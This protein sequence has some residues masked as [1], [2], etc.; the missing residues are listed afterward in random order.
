MH[1]AAKPQIQPEQVR[2]EG[3]LSQGQFGC[4]QVRT[5]E[6]QRYN[7]TRDLEGSKPGQRVWVEGYVVKTKG[8]MPGPSLMP[9]HAG[10]VGASLAETTVP[11]GNGRR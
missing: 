3:E 1:G 4:L 2:V 11:A 10:L 8:C 5:A 7:L 6:G 9:Q